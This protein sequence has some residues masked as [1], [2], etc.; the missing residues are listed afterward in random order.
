M[1]RLQAGSADRGSQLASVHC[2][3]RGHLRG[4]RQNTAA[5]GRRWARVA[6][7]AA[8]MH[9]PRG[10]FGGSSPEGKAAGGLISLFTSA[11]VRVSGG[12]G[13]GV[14][15]CLCAVEQS[16]CD[17]GLRTAGSVCAAGGQ[18]RTVRASCTA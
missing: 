17:S 18:Q 15:G 10:M 16:R 12:L 11:A 6:A 1:W 13:P 5:K 3:L 8:K 7:P 14:A 9:V 4:L 2:H